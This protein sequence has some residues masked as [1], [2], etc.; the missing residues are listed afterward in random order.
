MVILQSLTTDI[1]ESGLIFELILCMGAGA[2]G[3]AGW[4]PAPKVLVVWA[5]MHLALQIIGLYV[6]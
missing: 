6:R 3:W 2:K 1:S 4:A 5:T